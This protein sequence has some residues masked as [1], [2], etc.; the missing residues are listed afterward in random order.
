[1]TFR[2]LLKQKDIHGA[3]LARKLG[4]TRSVVS[5]WVRG[6]NFPSTIYLTKI[7]EILGISLTDLLNALSKTKEQA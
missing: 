2:E 4:V 5:N 3:Q 1:M 7:A 6:K